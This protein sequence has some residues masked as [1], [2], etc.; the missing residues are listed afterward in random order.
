ME[1]IVTFLTVIAQTF[2]I[3]P[4]A[5]WLH[6]TGSPDDAALA[7]A[8]DPSQYHDLAIAVDLSRYCD[9]ALAIHRK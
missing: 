6:Y 7:I 8:V 1:H 3:D 2:K 5:E 4:H 9:L